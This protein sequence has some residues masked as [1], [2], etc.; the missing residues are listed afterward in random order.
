MK[1]TTLN[2]SIKDPKIK[3]VLKIIETHKMDYSMSSQLKIK[4]VPTQNNVASKIM[5][6]ASNWTLS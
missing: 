1:S 2:I 6:L 5:S 3:E 4:I